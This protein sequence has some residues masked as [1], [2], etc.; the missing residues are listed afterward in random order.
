[1]TFFFIANKSVSDSYLNI[2]NEIKLVK[3]VKALKSSYLISSLAIFG[4]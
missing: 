2:K 1:M 3:L 4:I